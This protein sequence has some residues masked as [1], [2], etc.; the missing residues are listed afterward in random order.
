M[1]PMKKQV[2]PTHI[3]L[4]TFGSMVPALYPSASGKDTIVKGVKIHYLVEGE[5][6]SVVLIHGLYSSIKMNWQMPCIINQLAS[7]IKMTH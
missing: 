4:V 6:P 1:S 5:G 7:Q 2:W 3:T